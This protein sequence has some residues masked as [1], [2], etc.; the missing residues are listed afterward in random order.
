MS[1]YKGAHIWTILEILPCNYSWLF[2]SSKNYA[3]IMCMKLAK[4]VSTH[5]ENPT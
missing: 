5:K 1:L 4:M 2:I 3:M